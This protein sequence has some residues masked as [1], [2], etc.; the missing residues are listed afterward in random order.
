[1]QGNQLLL[2]TDNRPFYVFYMQS[3]HCFFNAYSSLKESK[4]EFKNMLKN[5][6]RN[7]LGIYNSENNYLY[8]HV[9]LKNHKRILTRRHMRVV[10]KHYK[11]IIRYK[12]RLNR[13]HQFSKV[14]YFYIT[15]KNN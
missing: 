3:E 8:L 1:M 6:Q 11:N 12:L 13:N 5:S 15:I 7:P 14:L 10:N 9:P 4:K 2:F